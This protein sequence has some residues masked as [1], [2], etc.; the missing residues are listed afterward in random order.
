MTELLQLREEEG[1]S[2][3]EVVVAVKIDRV[4][5]KEEGRGWS[6]DIMTKWL[7]NMIELRS[8]MMMTDFLYDC[9]YVSTWNDCSIISKWYLEPEVEP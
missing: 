2:E 8:R 1:E 6:Y 3:E 5:K 9:L 4:V 7:F